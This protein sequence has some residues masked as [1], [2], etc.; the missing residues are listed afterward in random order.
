MLIDKQISKILLQLEFIVHGIVTKQYFS[1]P[2]YSSYIFKEGG[3]KKQNLKP[4]TMGPECVLLGFLIQSRKTLSME[5]FHS[6]GNLFKIT[7]NTI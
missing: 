5:C 6:G 4:L 2:K 1:P 3:G 7:L